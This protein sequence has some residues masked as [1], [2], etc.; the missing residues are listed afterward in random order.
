M[1]KKDNIW[2]D[3]QNQSFKPPFDVPDDYF[4]SLEDRIEGRIAS[5]TESISPKGKLI[6]MMKPIL[7]MAASFALIFVLVYYPMSVFLPDYLAK[8]AN[9]H[10]EESDSLS[11][12]EELFSYILMSDQSLYDILNNETE[13][14]DEKIDAEEILDYLSIA[15]NETDI[16][17]ELQN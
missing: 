7:G 8:N 5:E 3:F 13:Q 1:N 10:V 14:A 11:E 12:N 4:N 9:I 15:M 6:R 2:T 17:A 16:Y